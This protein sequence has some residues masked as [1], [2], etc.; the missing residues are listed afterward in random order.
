[1]GSDMHVETRTAVARTTPPSAALG[2]TAVLCVTCLQV[3]DG[4]Q[5]SR[6]EEACRP[7]TELEICPLCPWQAEPA[8]GVGSWLSVQ[9]RGSLQEGRG[10]RIALPPR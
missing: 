9:T 7:V 6:G 1:M 5:A 10:A 3:C 2:R 4:T 8:V